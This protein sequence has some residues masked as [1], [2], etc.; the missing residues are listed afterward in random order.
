MNRAD[1]HDL[2]K[3]ELAD[4]LESGISSIQPI[5]PV[6]LGVIAVV[7]VGALGFGIYSA[8]AYSGQ[9]EAWSEYYLRLTGADSETFLEV[10][11]VYPE[12]KMAD[13]ARLNAADGYL[14]SGLE[15]LYKNRKEAEETIGLAITNY[16]QVLDSSESEELTMKV[17]LGL[18]RAHES[19]GELDKAIGYYEQFS[20][21]AAPPQMIEN[22][23]AQLAFLNSDSGKSFYEWFTKLEPSPDAPITL[24][25]N[26]N[27][28]PADPNLDFGPGSDPK[29]LDPTGLPLPIVDGGSEGTVESVGDLQLPEQGEA[30]PA[31]GATAEP[32]KTPEAEA[33]DEGE[34]ESAEGDASEGDSE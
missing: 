29:P 3:N 31:E 12:S 32:A 13:W 6:I 11:D 2:E 16:E 8:N 25:E 23:N 14:Q 22:V 1:R 18:G 5:L 34:S 21:S 10:A 26:M 24:P 19:L 27:L 9:A 28:P 17:L 20:S 15:A 7:V 4:R 33:G 30:T